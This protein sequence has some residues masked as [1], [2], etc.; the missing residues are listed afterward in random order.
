[1]LLD[2]SNITSR[3][4]IADTSTKLVVNL[5]VKRDENSKEKKFKSELEGT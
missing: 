2:F 3:I 1:M 4:L 5:H